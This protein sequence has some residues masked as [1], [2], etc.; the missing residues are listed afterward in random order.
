MASSTIGEN[1]TRGDTRDKEF[2][3]LCGSILGLQVCAEVIDL[4]RSGRGYDM[5]VNR[6]ARGG[7]GERVG[8][9]VGERNGVEGRIRSIHTDV[10]CRRRFV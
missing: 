5:S 2:W 8:E 9:R 4:L 1:K 3:C 10:V 7:F 6:I